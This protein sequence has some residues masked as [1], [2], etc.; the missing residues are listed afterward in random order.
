MMKILYNS[1]ILLL[2]SLF[3]VFFS[4]SHSQIKSMA[5][6]FSRMGFDAKGLAMGN[7]M[8]ACKEGIVSPYYN[9][10]TIVFQE[11]ITFNATYTF[12][13]LDRNLNTF[14]FILPVKI[15]QDNGDILSAALSGG[16]INAGVTNIDGRDYDGF[17]T[18]LLSTFENQFYFAAAVKFTPKLAIGATFKFNYAKLY[19]EIT[20]SGFGVDAGLIYQI[21][22]KFALAVTVKDINT[23]YE[24]DTSELYGQSGNST[25][26]KF[27]LL[28][29]IGAG[30]KVNED[31]YT[32]VSF[33]S[34]NQKSNI[35]KFGA[36]Y[37]INSALQIRA[38]IDRLDISNTNN[39]VKPSFGFSFS[40][41]FNILKP[42]L[43]YV[44][45]L[46]PFTHYPLQMITLT[47]QL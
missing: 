28:K 16:L 22:E 39:G 12:L 46:E 31:L 25:K 17:Q 33:E 1:K 34:S 47:I 37:S 41:D 18:G 15:K 26:D 9:P 24:W 36:E 4:Y 20:S 13:N 29:I 27:P 38:G 14:S 2:V 19:D 40:H 42:T 43:N 35:L 32:T 21:T 45:A 7:S 23:S 8:T 10:S 11:E 6:S 44:F 5:G 30:Y 3:F